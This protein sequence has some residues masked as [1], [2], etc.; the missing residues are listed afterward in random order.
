[1]D[2]QNRLNY[3]DG[4]GGTETVMLVLGRSGNFNDQANG[5]MGE[6]VKKFSGEVQKCQEMP[7]SMSFS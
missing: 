5:F 6:N 7:I 3:W 4:Q 2:E 1:M